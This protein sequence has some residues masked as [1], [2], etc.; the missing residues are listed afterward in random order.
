MIKVI[1]VDDE[2]RQ[3]QA[4]IKH[5]PWHRY[6]MIVTG[7]AENAAQALELEAP[8]VLITDIRLVGSSGLELA[9]RMREIH[10]QLRVIMMTGYEQ[11][12]YAKTALDIGVNAFLIKPVDF[13][14]LEE[15]LNEIYEKDKERRLKEEEQ[16]QL[17]ERLEGYNRKARTDF[18]MDVLHGLIVYNQSLEAQAATMGVLNEP[19]VRRV[20][21]VSGTSLDAELGPQAADMAAQLF[22]EELE[23]YLVTARGETVLILRDPERLSSELSRSL[24]SYVL[25]L[26]EDGYHVVLGVGGSAR[27][28]S[29]LSASYRQAMCAIN[30]RILGNLNP[31]LYWDELY[32]GEDDR[33][34]HERFGENRRQFITMVTG[35]DGE[36]ALHVLGAMMRQIVGDETMR[37]AELRSLCMDLVISVFEAIDGPT[38]AWPEVGGAQTIRKR[39]L[40]CDSDQEA[41]QETVLLLADCCRRTE[42]TR[43]HTLAV[44]QR[45]VEYM[46]TNY[47]KPL[48]LR[49]VAEE[50]YLSPNYLGALLR[51]EMGISFTEQLTLIRIAQAKVLLASPALKLYEVA[52]QVGYHN[53]GH[54]TALFKRVTGRSPKEYR[55]L[56]Y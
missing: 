21:V 17:L 30:Q 28:L 22:R 15:I 11:F 5:L 29:G 44:V 1:V 20:I 47:M 27:R 38:E 36:A 16:K 48:S 8:D 49:S 41:V 19:Y 50:V 4:I 53:V 55:L 35:G 32:Q 23:E 10:P 40:A 14:K 42:R 51:A 31:I 46:Q 45:A 18:L 7:E 37:G 6:N 39:L 12:D 43:S 26:Q 9:A 2:I 24:Q 3:R 56:H 34:D 25:S 52:E 54:F 13:S 33:P